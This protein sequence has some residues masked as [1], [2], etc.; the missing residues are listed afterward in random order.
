[1]R[2]TDRSTIPWRSYFTSTGL[3]GGPTG[4]LEHMQSRGKQQSCWILQPCLISPGVHT[5]LR[6]DTLAGRGI[7]PVRSC[8]SNTF[9]FFK[10][11]F[12][13][14]R[15]ANTSWLTNVYMT[16][17]AAGIEDLTVILGGEWGEVLKI[18][19]E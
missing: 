15:L 4:S 12:H 1:M 17:K 14:K 6:M 13:H 18:K 2:N 3:M 5:Q 19:P 8:F 10:G 11:H 9:R 16:K 7:K